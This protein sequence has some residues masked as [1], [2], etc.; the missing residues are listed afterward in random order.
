MEKKKPYLKLRFYYII[1]WLF[2]IFMLKNKIAMLTI[3]FMQY[4][5]GHMFK[6]VGLSPFKV[7]RSSAH[8]LLVAT[9]LKTGEPC[10]M[11]LIPYS[12]CDIISRSDIIR[13]LYGV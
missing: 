11:P 2:Y 12:N 7:I 5:K 3:D 6:I 13:T 10:E 8:Y 1:I 4:K 9:D